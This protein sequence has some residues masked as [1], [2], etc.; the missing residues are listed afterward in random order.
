MFVRIIVI[1][2]ANIAK[3]KRMTLLAKPEVNALTFYNGIGIHI[4]TVLYHRKIG[5]RRKLE[6]S[7]VKRIE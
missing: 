5:N 7:K 1:C 6:L 4:I 2:N 3:K